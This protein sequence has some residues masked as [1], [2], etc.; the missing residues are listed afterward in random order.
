MTTIQPNPKLAFMR[1]SSSFFCRYVYE[2]EASTDSANSVSSQYIIQTPVSSPGKIS[3]P[4]NVSVLGPRSVFVAWSLP[5]NVFSPMHLLYL[6]IIQP[7]FIHASATESVSMRWRKFTRRVARIVMPASRL[8]DAA[9]NP[10][11]PHSTSSGELS[12]ISMIL[13][14]CLKFL[15]QFMFNVFR[16]ILPDIFCF[17]FYRGFLE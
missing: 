4:S 13:R 3:A 6:A 15:L 14:G 5:G 8:L 12:N 11:A 17:L 7:W 2:L 9:E 1:S 10:L 16:F